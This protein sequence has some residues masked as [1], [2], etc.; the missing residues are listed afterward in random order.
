MMHIV[1]LS[2]IL[3][4]L[5]TSEISILN[6]KTYSNMSSGIQNVTTDMTTLKVAL[7][8]YLP[9]SVGDNYTREGGGGR[10]I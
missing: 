4:V 1:A 6:V 8:P 2:V 9:D 10:L 3:L 7:F 5:F